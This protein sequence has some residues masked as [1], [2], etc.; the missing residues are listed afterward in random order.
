MGK[1]T[2]PLLLNETG[3]DIAAAIRGMRGGARVLPLAAGQQLAQGTIID[4]VGIPMYVDDVSALA[5]YGITETGWYILARISAPAGVTVSGA[6][7]VD[8][9]AAIIEPGADQVWGEAAE[10]FVFRAADLAV[11]NL[12][13]R[14]T[15]YVYDVAPYTTWE[16]ALTADAVFA[17]GKAYYTEAGGEYSRAEVQTVAYVLTS[18][19]TFQAGKTYY[20]L[21]G[22]EFIAAEV[23][24]GEAV[25]PGVYYEAT[26]VAVPAYY[27]DAYQLTTDATFQDGVTYYTE[28]DG[29]YTAAE[30]TVG[31][32]V[33]PDT[34]Y[35]VVKVQATGAFE[36][37]V[38]YYTK[39]GAEYVLA[40]VTPGA[41][42]PAYYN[43]SKVTFSG[44]TRN[45]TYKLDELVD[46]PIAFVLPEVDDD[47]YG[48][49]YEVQINCDGTYSVELT[50]ED[51]EAKVASNTFVSLSAGVFVL[52]LQYTA[53]NGV[54][55]WR[56]L[57]TQATLPTT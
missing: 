23:T 14:T 17:A 18:D 16:Y 7:A 2:K 56:L 24:V 15:F 49:W 48:A 28:A 51:A 38:T 54:K 53:V 9:A 27:V 1:V 52:D 6:T 41:A 3:Q 55:V 43:H 47:G 25:A 44:M 32:A 30:V 4:A 13:Y 45:I 57:R 50:L 42:I 12:D 29:V 33:E 40:T 19:E 5:E 36:S 8:G 39:S 34:Y 22:T 35:V 20:I 46:C 11:R 26:T 37:G 31:E 21:S 10:V